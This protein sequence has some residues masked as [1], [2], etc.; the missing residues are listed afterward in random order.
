MKFLLFF[1][2]VLFL[3]MSCKKHQAGNTCV[4]EN[5]KQAKYPGSCIDKIEQYTY[6]GQ[7]VYYFAAGQSCADGQSRLIDA[8]C[9][10]LCRRGGISGETGA[11]CPD[12]PDSASFVR[13]V[14]ERH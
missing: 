4:Q 5:I 7:A 9:S 10:E 6:H 14:W 11:S 8:N 3:L 13:I 12:F 2:P 1:T